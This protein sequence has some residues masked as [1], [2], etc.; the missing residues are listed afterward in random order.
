MLKTLGEIFVTAGAV[1][2]GIGIL[3]CLIWVGQ[4]FR[5]MIWGGR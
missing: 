4:F 1:C 3:Y 5:A 2:T